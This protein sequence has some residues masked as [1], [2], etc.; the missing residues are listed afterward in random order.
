MNTTR[1]FN[2]RPTLRVR[3]PA[4]DPRLMGGAPSTATNA[5]HPAT[6]HNIPVSV[7]RPTGVPTAGKDKSQVPVSDPNSARRVPNGH[8]YTP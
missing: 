6:G 4:T 7:I 3:S 1:Q 5:I 2:A 8:G